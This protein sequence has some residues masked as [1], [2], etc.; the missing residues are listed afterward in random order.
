MLNQHIKLCHGDEFSRCE[1]CGKIYNGE[2]KL[3]AHLKS[4]HPDHRTHTCPVVDC[5]RS[6]PV[7][8]L[9]LF[10][11]DDK[12]EDET[13]QVEKPF[14]CSNPGC[15]RRF[16]SQSFLVRHEQK[17]KKRNS[18]KDLGG[19]LANDAKDMT[20][21][22]EVEEKEDNGCQKMANEVENKEGHKEGKGT[23]EVVNDGI[24]TESGTEN[25]YNDHISDETCKEQQCPIC[26]QLV[27]CTAWFK[28]Q[29]THS[30][31]FI[32]KDCGKVC[33]DLAHRR[34]HRLAKHQNVKFS[35]PIELCGKQLGSRE[36]LR[37]H[38][39]FVHGSRSQCQ[40]C[41]KSFAL[42]GDLRL[43]IQG[44]H[45]GKKANCRY[46]ESKFNRPSDRNRHERQ[47]HGADS[48]GKRFQAQVDSPALET[49]SV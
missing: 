23:M 9:L 28:H 7:V 12:H 27:L 29:R 34:A 11:M 44:A 26:G 14:V 2:W 3:R 1:V 33:R 37:A 41:D 36:T 38:I 31:Q 24:S 22:P 40:F 42:L 35:C 32:C 20:H 17:H 21:H 48:V 15:Q 49:D 16:R 25:I 8:S 13:S 19:K 39:T 4:V 46:C 18:K 45:E 5:G 43:H 10:H 6:F 30:R 47:V